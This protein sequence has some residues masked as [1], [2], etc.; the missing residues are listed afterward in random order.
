MKTKTVFKGGSKHNF[1]SIKE[2]A[3]NVTL[4]EKCHKLKDIH[5][6]MKHLLIEEKQVQME[7]SV[8]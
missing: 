5:K 8:N 7:T 3:Y 2:C 1:C 4:F 6:I